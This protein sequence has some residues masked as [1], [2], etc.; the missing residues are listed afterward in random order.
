MKIIISF[1]I[2]FSL[3]YAA[4]AQTSQ[5]IYNYISK[6]Y[7]TTLRDGL[8]IKRG[9]NFKEIIKGPEFTG[10]LSSNTYQFRYRAF[11]KET[12]ENN[13]LAFMIVLLKNGA[14]DKVFCMPSYGSDEELWGAFWT[15][16]NTYLYTDQKA[17]L[18]SDIF[19]LFTLT[20]KGGEQLGR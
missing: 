13:T 10:S 7:I 6:G 14:V 3:A 20:V 12:N 4:K 2:C 8:D 18:S 16:I 5:E 15:D 9:Y 1:T 17:Q 11:Y 19:N